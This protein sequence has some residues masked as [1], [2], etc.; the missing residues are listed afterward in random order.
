MTCNLVLLGSAAQGFYDVIRQHLATAWD[1][2][3]VNDADAPGR[4]TEADVVVSMAFNEQHGSAMR[5]KLIQV[6]GAGYDGIEWSAVPSGTVVCN[7][8]EHEVGCAEYAMLGML[9]WSIR[10]GRADAELRAGDWSRS[11]R[12][13]GPP[14]AELRDKTVGIVGLGRIGREVARR[15]RAFNMPILAANRTVRAPGGEADRIVGLGDL[16]SVA[17]QADFLVVSCALTPDT[18]GLIDGE[19]LASMRPSAV[20]INVARGPVIDEE[21]LWQALSGARIGGAVLDVWWQNPPDLTK[22]VAPSRFPFETLP[23]VLMSPHIA[24]WTTGTV[25]RRGRFMAANIDRLARGEEPLNVVR[26][27]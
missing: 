5:L 20:V 27:S 4:L 17:E 23:N 8:F 19:I 21:A 12:F 15:A 10:L 14:S 24:G 1:I 22:P 7:V 11:S 26:P 3:L 16:T 13:G 9:E 6:P 25:A 2:S 18:C